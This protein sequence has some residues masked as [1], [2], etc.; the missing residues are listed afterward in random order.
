M[1]SR[2]KLM[3]SKIT[4]LDAMS[5][6]E[7]NL[8]H[9]YPPLDNFSYKIHTSASIIL[10]INEHI[11]RHLKREN[12]SNATSLNIECVHE[13]WQDMLTW[14]GSQPY[15]V[16]LKK[17]KMTKTF[18]ATNDV[19]PGFCRCCWISFSSW[20]ALLSC[21]RS[22]YI[23]SRTNNNRQSEKNVKRE[24]NTWKSV[25]LTIHAAFKIWTLSIHISF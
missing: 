6:R 12:T 21:L 10:M 23:S 3:D 13:C 8:F 11:A 15:S 19:S 7:I 20:N 17:S 24:R 18:N 14:L 25:Y 2:N 1:Y 9:S 5:C 16:R 22:A 4:M